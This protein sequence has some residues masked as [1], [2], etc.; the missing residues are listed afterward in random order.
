MSDALDPYSAV[1]L[2]SYGGPRRSEDVLP[3]MRNATAGRG[4]PDERLLEVSQH[5]QLFG[6]RSPINEQNEALRDALSAELKRRGCPR[7]VVIGNRNWTPFFAETVSALQ[8]DQHDRVVAVATAAYSC[9]SACRQYREDLDAAMTQVPGIV[10]DK[11]GPYAERGGFV[12]ANVD[13]LVT[14]VRTLRSRIGDG[15][16]KVLFVTHSIPTAMN[17]ASADGSPAARYDAQHIRVASRV[18]EAAEAYLGER[19]DWELTYC[20]RSGSPRIPWLEPDVNDRLAEL[21][22]VD[23]VV[24]AP[25]GFISDH[26]EVVYDLDTQARESASEIG[27]DYERAATAGVHPDFIAAIADLLLEQAAVARGE[28]TLPHHPCLTESVRCCLPHPQKEPTHVPPASH[29]R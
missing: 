22:G 17:A 20:S 25:I 26:M 6:G 12:S 4:V 16:L 28:L 10:I 15:V 23:G 5:Y 24:A 14:A 18:A 21:T 13:A 27:V 8:H 2:A 9:Y 11:V 19:L 3:F 7:P 1:L 29:A